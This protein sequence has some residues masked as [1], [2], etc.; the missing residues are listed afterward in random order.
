MEFIRAEDVFRD[1][2]KEIMASINAGCSGG[3]VF[4]YFHGTTDVGVVY[5]G[6]VILASDG[7]AAMGNFIMSDEFPKIYRLDKHSAVAIAGAVRPCLDLVGLLRA[8]FNYEED[9]REGDYIPPRTKVKAISNAIKRITPLVNV[10]QVV[11]S[12]IFAVFDK[13][14]KDPCG[15][16]F[17]VYHDGTIAPE[18]A[19][20]SLGSGS[21]RAVSAIRV[22]LKNSN[23]RD[24]SEFNIKSM[25]VQ[26]LI[27]ASEGDSG[28][29]PSISMRKVSNEGVSEI[30]SEEINSIKSRIE[31][32]G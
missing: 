2:E 21:Q 17:Q 4:P 7:R 24:L 20:G 23:P 15:R 8:R 13:D 27:A 5:N 14:K 16:M 19:F 1:K 25:A 11:A 12:M 30:D 31:R 3:S 9:L 32:G 22:M 29:G 18:K 6:G 10:N 26:A 28:T